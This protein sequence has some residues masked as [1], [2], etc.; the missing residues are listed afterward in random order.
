MK[1]KVLDKA[2]VI[3]INLAVIIAATVTPALI[4]ASSPSYYRN[5]FEKNGF[6]SKTDENGSVSFRC[7]PFLGGADGDYACYTDEQLNAIADHIIDFLFGDTE[8]FEL[9]MDG[10]V[11]NGEKRDEVRIFGDKAISH[12]NDVKSLMSLGKWASI[13]SI[14]LLPLLIYY[15]VRRRREIGSTALQYSLIFFAFIFLILGVLCVFSLIFYD[16][17]FFSSFWECAHYLLFPFNPEKVQGSFFNDT[18]TV[19][20]SL[21]LFMD[22]VITVLTTLAVSLA[23]WFTATF[24]LY[25][26]DR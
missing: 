8:S 18:L 26:I 24:L 12:M 19:I 9:V 3:L 17:N 14:I 5:Q 23:I 1:M 13:I 20:L 21:D 10:V 15:L 11:A 7:I 25:K 16:G 4:L 6:Y 22:A 2:V